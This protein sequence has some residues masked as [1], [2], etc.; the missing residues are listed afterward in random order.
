[1]GDFNIDLL[2][3]NSG[4]ESFFNLMFLHGMY[5]RIDRPTRITDSSATLID[6]IFTNVYITQLNSGVWVADIADHL[7][8]YT[9]LPYM[10]HPMAL[11]NYIVT[12]HS[13]CTKECTP[14][15]I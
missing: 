7:P 1:M 15:R 5:P 9:I 11:T 13:T 3:N 14:K 12:V 2:N 10:A 8:V 6:N 4:S